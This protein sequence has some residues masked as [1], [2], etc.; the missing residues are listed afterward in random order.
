MNWYNVIKK[1][2]MKNKFTFQPNTNDIMVS[3][4][5]EGHVRSYISSNVSSHVES[6]ITF[7]KALAEVLNFDRYFNM[8]F[9][10]N[11]SVVNVIVKTD[12]DSM[13]NYK[14]STDPFILDFSEKLQTFIDEHRFNY[15]ELRNKHDPVL[16]RYRELINVQLHSSSSVEPSA[17]YSNRNSEPNI[18]IDYESVNQTSHASWTTSIL[19]RLFAPLSITSYI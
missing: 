9:S 13:N 17:P 15:Q 5:L 3:I 14:Q 4:T 18:R 11:F 19:S 10:S 6:R 7:Q 8:E 1:D 16:S 2:M 12:N